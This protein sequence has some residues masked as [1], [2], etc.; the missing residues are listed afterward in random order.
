MEQVRL[1]RQQ[2][3]FVQ[4]KNQFIAACTTR[5][6]GKTNAL[7][8]KFLNTMQEYPGSLCRYIAL[9]RDSA[10]DIMWPVLHELNDRFDLA[11]DFNESNLTMQLPNEAKLRLYG[12]D[13]KNVMRR[14]RGAKSPANAI[15]EAQ[16]FGPHIEQLIDDILTPTMAD[17]PNAW[18]AITGT[19]GPIPRG[20]FFDATE[21]GLGGYSVHRWSLYDNP[22]LPNPRKFVADLKAKKRWADDTPAYL[23][24]YC[25]KW[26]LDLDS[27]LVRYSAAINHFEAL[28]PASF[29]YILGVDI[30]HRDSDALALLAYT[31]NA[32]E[33]YLVQELVTPGQDITALAQQIDLLRKHYN[34]S[35]IV[36]D[37]G[38]LG[39]KV[40]EEITRRKHIPIMAADK[41]RKFENVALLNDWLRIGK[42]KAKQESR[43]ATDSMLV[44][45]DHDKTTP[46]KLVVKS[47]FH[48]DIIDAVLYAFRECMAF[49]HQATQPKHAYGSKEWAEEQVMDMER[50]A[51]EY[52]LSQA[53]STE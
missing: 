22:Y 49:T 52:F 41:K 46:D 13:M 9:T 48:S 53:E 38:G 45:I 34:V 6:A 26:V 35:K 50:A 2:N 24:E 37:T 27:L 15:D 16:E 28:P 4:D 29:N 44:Q 30:G 40:A 31:D 10:K 42:F 5:R 36:M 1:F 32:N 23:R 47:N 7:A 39:L 25:G 12:A 8:L 51:E 18:L 17:Y 19:P 14:L 21:K 43:F 11:A 33:I 20:L 3:E